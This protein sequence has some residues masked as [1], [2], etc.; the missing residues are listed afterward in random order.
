MNVLPARCLGSV[1][2]AD[3]QI[4]LREVEDT[5]QRE[6]KLLAWAMDLAGKV[7]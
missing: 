3:S 6:T 5:V 7:E 1:F 2:G 4:C